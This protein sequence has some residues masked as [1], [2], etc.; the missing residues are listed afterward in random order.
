MWREI[1]FNNW[2]FLVFFFHFEDEGSKFLNTFL[3]IEQ[4]TKSKHGLIP[5]EN[6]CF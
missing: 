4:L 5:F 6:K 3:K 2:Q 1:V